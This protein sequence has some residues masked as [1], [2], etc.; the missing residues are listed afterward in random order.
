MIIKTK[1]FVDSEADTVYTDAYTTGGTVPVVML[2][3][4]EGT[5][6]ATTAEAITAL[7]DYILFNG[8]NL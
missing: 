3:R 7:E 8:Y 1:L 5:D 2:A 4:I 6:D